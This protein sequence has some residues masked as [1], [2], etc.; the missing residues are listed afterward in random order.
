MRLF[1]YVNCVYI[2]L[3]CSLTKYR[4]ISSAR[5]IKLQ[6]V[7]VGDT[8]VAKYQELLQARAG[9][10]RKA[11]KAKSSRKPV[12]KKKR[13]DIEDEKGMDDD[14]DDEDDANINRVQRGK[15][16]Q[17]RNEPSILSFGVEKFGELQSASM[18]LGKVGVK[19]VFDLLS[20]KHV[21]QQQIVGK[22]KIM[23]DIQIRSG[24]IINFPATIQFFEDGSLKTQFESKEYL[25]KYEFI[26]N[27]WPRK[28]I[29]KFEARACIL[30]GE[31]E[32]VLLSYK[33]YFKRSLMKQNVILMRGKIYKS[34]GSTL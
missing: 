29:I 3:F 34:S 6:R 26:E 33:G 32:P 19:S 1:L 5:V 28:C 8:N 17:K 10:S 14:D 27:S 11:I 9:K 13:E 16:S 24:V 25:S 15:R 7:T 4:L 20:N 22:W 30:T 18:K 2:V 21:T 31:S 12:A 23:Q